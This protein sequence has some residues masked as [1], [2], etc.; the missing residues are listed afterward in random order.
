VKDL[1]VLVEK[2][3]KD[4]VLNNESLSSAFEQDKQDYE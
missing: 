4:M 3:K 1:Y 2:L